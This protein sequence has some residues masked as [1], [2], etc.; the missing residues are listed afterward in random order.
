MNEQSTSFWK[1]NK[2][3]FYVFLA[4]ILIAIVGLLSI[5]S[6]LMPAFS[7]GTTTYQ[8]AIVAFGGDTPNGASFVPNL[9]LLVSYILVILAFG[10]MILKMNE[11]KFIIA[12]VFYLGAGIMFFLTIP[13]NDLIQNFYIDNKTLGGGPILAGTLLCFCAFGAITLYVLAKIFRKSSG[14][15]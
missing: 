14:G 9:F 11:I 8:L 6:V 2:K 12:G 15:I 3:G 5:L 7:Q 4:S 10:A 13:I 1:T